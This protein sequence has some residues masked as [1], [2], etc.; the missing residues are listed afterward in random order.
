M[1]QDDGNAVRSACG[2]LMT[3]YVGIASRQARLE[4]RG[5]LGRKY[6]PSDEEYRALQ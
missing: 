6:E 3:M 1:K 5:Y 2:I 4:T